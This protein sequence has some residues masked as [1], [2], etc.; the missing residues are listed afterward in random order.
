MLVQPPCLIQQLW[1]CVD[2]TRQIV[3]QQRS[4]RNSHGKITR[5]GSSALQSRLEDQVRHGAYTTRTDAL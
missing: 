5:A 3:V 4:Q 1:T 2:V